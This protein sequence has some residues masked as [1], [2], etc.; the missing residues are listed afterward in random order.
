MLATPVKRRNRR[1]ADQRDEAEALERLGGTPDR[2]PAEQ[3]GPHRPQL[4]QQQGNGGDPGDDVDALVHPV[5][6]DRVHRQVEPGRRVLG[7]V[8]DQPGGEAQGEGHPQGHPQ[9]RGHPLVVQR[10]GEPGPHLLGGLGR[11]LHQRPGCPGDPGAQARAIGDRAIGYRAI[12]YRAI[13]DGGLG[14]R[15]VGGAGRH[16]HGSTVP[17]GRRRGTDGTLQMEKFGAAAP[18]PR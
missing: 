1:A 13:G 4:G 10:A 15:R 9:H 7:Q 14:A 6:V 8:V 2:R 18:P 12:G 11:P 17:P 5:E 16:G 3:L